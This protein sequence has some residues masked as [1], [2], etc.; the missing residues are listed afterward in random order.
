MVFRYFFLSS[1]PSTNCLLKIRISHR[2]YSTLIL[3]SFWFW[4]R[5]G[6]FLHMAQSHF[7]HKTRLIFVLSRMD[8]ARVSNSGNVLGSFWMLS[9]LA[10][11]WTHSKTPR[12]LESHGKGL[13]NLP[14]C[15]REYLHFWSWLFPSCLWI[16][17][18]GH[19]AQITK[20]LPIWFMPA[21]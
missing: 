2:S 9:L 16:K 21:S 1:S 18:A 3:V 5:S 20:P 4:S 6:Y 14:W 7:Q 8:G 19:Y 13:A 11:S 15:Q 17:W 10:E 12:N